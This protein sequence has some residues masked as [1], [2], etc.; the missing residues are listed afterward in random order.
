MRLKAFFLKH[1]SVM[2]KYVYDRVDVKI[3]VG[4]SSFFDSVNLTRGTC[5]GVRFIPFDTAAKTA[6]AHAININIDANNGT[7]VLG[8]TDFRDFG[9][10]GGGY[11]DNFKPCNFDT[12][13]QINV[14][15]ISTEAISSEPFV[16]QLIFAIVEDCN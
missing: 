5:E 8:K 6:R 9:A 11:M 7:K 13:A 12:H 14:D 10:M 15:V 3:E 2:K 1:K 16:G 4:D